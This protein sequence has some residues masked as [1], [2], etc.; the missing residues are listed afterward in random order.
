MADEGTANPVPRAFLFLEDGDRFFRFLFTKP[1]V[2]L[3]RSEDND[4]VIR[5]EGILPRHA[6]IFAAGAELHLVA[7]AGSRTEL[8]GEQVQGVMPL[9]NGDEIRVADVDLLFVEERRQSE[10]AL[11]LIIQREGEIPFGVTI[12]KP[13]VRVGRSHGDVLID[14]DAISGTHLII[15]NFCE[16]GVFAIDARSTGGTFINGQRLVARKRVCDG[17]TLHIGNTQ[18]LVRIRR[19]GDA[20]HPRK[21]APKGVRASTEQAPRSNSSARAHEKPPVTRDA[22]D[23]ARGN[24]PGSPR[25]APAPSP[26]EPSQPALRARIRR[27]G[28]RPDPVGGHSSG[29]YEPP[30]RPPLPAS[31]ALPVAEPVETSDKR[32]RNTLRMP[33]RPGDESPAP[34]GQGRLAPGDVVRDPGVPAPSVVNID[35]P[36]RSSGPDPFVRASRSRAL[37]QEPRQEAPLPVAS[38]TR[39]SERTQRPPARSEPGDSGDGY[40]YLPGGRP[41]AP[42][43][44]PSA[45]SRGNDPDGFYYLPGDEPGQARPEP[46]RPEPYRHEPSRPSSKDQLAESVRSGHTIAFPHP[47]SGLVDDGS[48]VDQ[49][50]GRYYHP[51]TKRRG[52]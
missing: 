8:N 38:E 25:D 52:R 41:P 14:D 36:V 2:L 37:E 4:I 17:D 31:P 45:P 13:I 6:E 48:E 43:R 16:H 44:A 10:T 42:S 26:R 47:D 20:K 28:D 49:S 1:R 40:H 34:P 11:N 29:G 30:I 27:P 35:E 22:P 24:T 12:N 51:D 5:D 23:R 32:F 46:R 19:A 50:L 21:A 15:E 7:V 33:L 39:R 18:I 9:Q 3:G